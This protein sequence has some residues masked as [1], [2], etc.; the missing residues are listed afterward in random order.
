[1]LKSW[2]VNSI[3]QGDMV[4]TLYPC[5]STLSHTM[6]LVFVFLCWL[7]PH[8]ACVS[9]TQRSTVTNR[10]YYMMQNIERGVEKKRS[11]WVI[12]HPNNALIAYEKCSICWL[13]TLLVYNHIT[14]R[15]KQNFCSKYSAHVLLPVRLVYRQVESII[16]LRYKYIPVILII[17]VKR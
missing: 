3:I 11:V 13:Y 12:H 9:N 8:H 16:I 17:V 2:N 14:N 5:R 7:H 1:M 6:E 4:M 10:E 15:T